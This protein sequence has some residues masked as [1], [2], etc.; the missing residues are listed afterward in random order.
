[1]AEK[2]FPFIFYLFMKLST[3]KPFLL[4]IGC[5][6][7]IVLIH[8]IPVDLLLENFFI[9]DSYLI[10]AVDKIILDFVSLFSVIFFLVQCKIP[11]SFF[12]TSG[13]YRYFLPLILCVI[14]FSGGFKDFRVF[15]FST[16]EP[17]LFTTYILKTLSGAFLEEI[18]FR[19][20]VIGLL[21]NLYTYS[22]N[23]RL[24]VIGIS[25]I[26]FGLIHIINLWS[27]EASI[28][29]V[30]HQMYAA[31]CLGTMYGAIYIKTKNIFLL[32]FFHFLNNFFVGI[33]ELGF[34]K[35]NVKPIIENESWLEFFLE[36]FI[37][38]FYFGIPLIIGIFIMK[39][40]DKKD[41]KEL[42]GS[43]IK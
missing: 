19:G 4:I 43:R 22:P 20:M 28:E 32:A 10:Y 14:V 25:A 5:L 15:D 23:A 39:N 9:D 34:T 8:K 13:N 26:S 2:P 30:I 29:D 37:M 38:F 33:E 24:K 18:L 3:Y 1:M 16:V 17:L 35:N 42:M 36:E 40:I 11:V 7:L 41:L 27:F 6:F 12:S 21:I 31:A